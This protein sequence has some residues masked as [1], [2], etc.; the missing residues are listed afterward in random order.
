MRGLPT[1][2]GN[3]KPLL[4]PVPVK[5]YA[6]R[7][8]VVPYLGVRHIA[9][10]K[11]WKAMAKAKYVSSL[12]EEGLSLAQVARRIGSGRRTDVDKLEANATRWAGRGKSPP[13][14][15]PTSARV[16]NLY[17]DSTYAI[18]RYDPWLK[19]R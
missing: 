19:G 1:I 6:T 16:Q 14:S 10:V 5:V 7:A 13:D 4:N 3:V 17:Y 8:E 12:I 9:G 18:T 2:A 15:F 11:P